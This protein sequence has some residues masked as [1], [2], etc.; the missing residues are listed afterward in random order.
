MEE[1]FIP[2]AE[3]FKPEMIA[4]SSGLDMHFTD[5]YGSIKF[6]AHTYAEI[7]KLLTDVAERTCGGRIAMLLEGGYNLEAVPRAIA[8]IVTTLAELGDAEVMRH[9]EY[10]YRRFK[11]R[12]SEIKRILSDYW[13]IFK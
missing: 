4:V 12:V 8:T 6:T 3:A 11:N 13:N 1:L 10:K 2:L 5:L 7:T 9:S